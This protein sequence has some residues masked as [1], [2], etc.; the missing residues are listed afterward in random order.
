MPLRRMELSLSRPGRVCHVVC[1][2]QGFYDARIRVDLRLPLMITVTVAVVA[3]RFGA[4][5]PSKRPR[6]EHSR[7]MSDAPVDLN[8]L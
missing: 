8:L 4:W 1:R 2:P 6:S 5:R 7:V 3:G